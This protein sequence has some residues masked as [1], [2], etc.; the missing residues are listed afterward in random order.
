MLRALLLVLAL[1]LLTGGLQAAPSAAQRL[2]QDDLD[3]SR[4]LVQQERQMEA[5]GL[6]LEDW[7]AGRLAVDKAQGTARAARDRSAALARQVTQRAGKAGALG[8]AAAAVAA[9][10]AQAIQGTVQL[11]ESGSASR[12]DLLA[13][14]D[15]Q[16]QFVGRS[17]DR[18]LRARQ[19]HADRV[20]AASPAGSVKAYYQWQK[21]LLPLQLQEAALGLRARAAMNAL[22]SG[23]S[24][25][26]DGLTRS[27]QAVAQRVEALP[28]PAPVQPA[29]EAAVREAWSLARLVEAVE[30]MA[31]DPSPDS[32]SRV[33]RWSSSLRKD[34]ADAEDLSLEALA[35][36]LRS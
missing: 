30:L 27:G 6:A 35:R 10:R 15:R 23:T 14:A 5:A 2:A 33:R 19:A 24:A 17:L 13:F 34:S 8:T 32:N 22:G 11:L 4:L 21:A 9:E 36:A 20:L 25:A 28:A 31:A 29:Q 7:A 1:G 3:L 12:Q 18:W 16:S 26:T